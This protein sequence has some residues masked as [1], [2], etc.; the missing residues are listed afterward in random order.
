MDTRELIKALRTL[1][2]NMAFSPQIRAEAADKLEELMKLIDDV[3]GDH[4]VDYLDWYA[5]RCRELENEIE[6]LK[7]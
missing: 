1:P 7:K 4:Y 2:G 3:L 5:N 6:R